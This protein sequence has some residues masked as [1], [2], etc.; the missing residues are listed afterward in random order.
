MRIKKIELTNFKR[1]TKLTISDIP[2][3]SK[4]VLVIGSNGSGK[5]SL[6]DAFDWLGK[7]YKQLPYSLDET[8]NYYSKNSANEAMAL[9]EFTDGG[10]VQK[11][12]AVVTEGTELVKR[13]IGRSS[14]RIVPRISNNANPVNV[15]TDMDSPTTYIENDTRFINDVFL[16]IQQINNALREPVFSGKQADTLKIFRDFIEP[17]NNSLLKIFGGDETTTIQ[18]AEFHDATSYTT[19]KLIFK[20]GESKINYD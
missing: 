14:I 2:D 20:K 13:F 15:S 9:V 7:G 6:F 1:F 19:A 16:Y 12:G 11:K 18:I 17:L 8:E 3:T 10:L 5:S 4:L